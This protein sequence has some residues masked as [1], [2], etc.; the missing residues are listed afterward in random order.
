MENLRKYGKGPYKVA[1][2][3]GGP[4]APGNM[5]PVAK[6]LS[7]KAATLEPL[8]T[9]SS[10]RGQVKEIHDILTE[11]C[12]G[13][14]NLIG[15]SWGAMLAFIF[16]SQYPELIK[17]LILI[18]SAAFDEK[19]ASKILEKRMERLDYLDV[20]NMHTIIEKLNNPEQKE[21]NVEFKKLVKILE[22]ADIFQ[23]IGNEDDTMAY[24]YDIYKSVWK[25]ALRLRKTGELLKLGKHLTC[26][27][28]AIHGDYD[29]HPAGLIKE[30]LLGV[31]KDLNFILLKNCGHYPWLEKKASNKFLKILIKELI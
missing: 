23:N 2:L 9:A 20:V 25:E 3:H 11:N 26:P 15:W 10:I 5:A 29:P 4:G 8:Q 16:T 24:Q 17:K 19:S 30:S 7:N 28:T 21:K 22:K 12:N 1:I 27:V 14:I 6:Y 18:S 13:K 31:L